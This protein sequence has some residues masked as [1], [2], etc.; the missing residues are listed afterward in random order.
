MNLK[1]L[2][3]AINETMHVGKISFTNKIPHI[4]K[5]SCSHDGTTDGIDW[6]LIVINNKNYY[7]AY[8]DE[9]IPMFVGVTQDTT[10]GHIEYTEFIAATTHAGFEGNSFFPRLLYFLKTQKQ[11]PVLIGDIISNATIQSLDKAYATGRFR[12]NWV[13]TDTNVKTKYN[14]T[15]VYTHTSVEQPTNIRLVVENTKPIFPR[16]R[17]DSILISDV[18]L[19]EDIE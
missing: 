5:T 11:K 1:E 8:S 6:F 9:D 18:I 3:V 19:F 10:I 14:Q 13:D 7:L 15:E 12:M 17:D 2:E 4:P 16:Y